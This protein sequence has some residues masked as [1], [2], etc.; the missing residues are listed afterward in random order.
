M[1][2]VLKVAPFKH[3]T[4]VSK[5]LTTADNAV[6]RF[7]RFVENLS[8]DAQRKQEEDYQRLYDVLKEGTE[9]GGQLQ[10]AIASAEEF[11]VLSQSLPAIFQTLKCADAVSHEAAEA[12]FNKIFHKDLQSLVGMQGKSFDSADFMPRTQNEDQDEDE[13]SVQD[14]QEDLDNK[15]GS[16]CSRSD[17]VQ[18]QKEA[19]MRMVSVPS[20]VFVKRIALFDSPAA[21]AMNS[22]VLVAL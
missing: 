15:G 1:C 7:R 19:V 10:V 3:F 22:T 4:W 8:Y 13:D 11:S 9:I 16:A 21:T 12:I 5:N 20:Y 17:P 14:Q 18:L 2:D 6:L